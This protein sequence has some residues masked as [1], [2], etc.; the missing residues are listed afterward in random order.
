MPV[1]DQPFTPLWQL[2]R[3]LAGG[4]RGQLFWVEAICPIARGV[5]PARRLQPSNLYFDGGFESRRIQ[6]PSE[7]I[8]L[9][10]EFRNAVVRVPLS[11]VYWAAT[12]QRLA[13]D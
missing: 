13:E 1:H 12:L 7:M 3:G 5:Q 6:L 11:R 9:L 2:A 4:L 10:P 8:E